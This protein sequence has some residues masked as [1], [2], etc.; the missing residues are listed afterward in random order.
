[1]RITSAGASLLLGL[2]V[3]AVALVLGG[4]Q[5]AR[6]SELGPSW[7]LPSQSG[8]AA[9]AAAA[10]TVDLCATAGSI[11]MPDT[12]VIPIWGFAP[13]DC[14]GS[15]VAQVPGS[16]IDVVEGDIVTVNLYN[17]LAENVSIVFPGQ[18]LIPDTVG[19]A[20]GGSASYVFTA[21]APATQLYESGTNASVQVAMGLYGALIVRPATA[22]QA[23]NDPATA[24]DSEAVLVLSEIDPALNQS[25]DPNTFN[26]VDYAPKYWLINGEAHPDTD[27]IPVTEGD[28]LLVR[29]L[30]AGLVQHTMEILGFH[31]TVVAGDGYPLGFPYEVVSQTIASGQTYDLIGTVPVTSAFTQYPLYSANQYVTNDA[32]FPGGMLTFVEAS[33]PAP[34]GDTVGP[35]TSNVSFV[36]SPTNGAAGATLSADVDETTTGGANVAAAEFFVSAVGADGTGIAMSGAFGSTTVAVSF[37]FTPGDLAAP[38]GS[39]TLYVHGQDALGNWGSTTSAVAVIDQTGPATS[40]VSASPNPTGGATSVTLTGSATD[41]TVVGAGPSNVVAA[42]WFEGADPGEGSGSPMSP[43]DGTFDSATEGLTASFDPSI[44]AP[45]NHTLSVRALD[46]AGNWGA[47]STTVLDVEAADLIFSDGFESGNFSAWDATFGGPARISVTSAAALQ[48]SFGMQS[49]ITGNT[50]SY[51]TDNTPANESSYHARFYFDPNS[52]ISSGSA[53]DILAGRNTAGATILR[54]QY[55]RTNGGLYQI[56]AGA[57]RSTGLAY[58]NWFT[59][60]DAP[61]AI[62]IAWQ[63]ATNASFSL[64]IDGVLRQTRT[65]LNTNTRKLDSVRLGPSVGLTIGTSGTEYFDSFVS[66]RNSYIGP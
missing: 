4:H 64:Y 16:T 53:H 54:V 17:N 62:E 13:G 15:P 66:T 65:G 22:G 19:A 24:Y 23:Y 47:V 35:V 9:P 25:A 33:P 28:R 29:Y 1:M 57:L 44:F 61:H 39:Y 36:P 7:T 8:P 5:E 52:T 46:E 59:V 37:G 42:E 34:P 60:S 27:P 41:P 50:P 45:D 43:S 21:G 26:F 20:P 49:V 51:V 40:G 11:T 10:V 63:S 6:A 58:T 18:S 2:A 55:R 3:L 48:G 38:E 30:N 14:T 12:T 31:Q 32:A 56:R